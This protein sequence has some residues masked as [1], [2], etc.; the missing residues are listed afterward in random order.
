MPALTTAEKRDDIRAL[1]LIDTR[2]HELA[3]KSDRWFDRKGYTLLSER[4]LDGTRLVAVALEAD[5]VCPIDA[6]ATMQIKYWVANLNRKDDLLAAFTKNIVAIN[7]HMATAAAQRV[8]GIVPKEAKHMTGFLDR[9]A[10]AG[11]CSR[12]DGAEV[13][14]GEGPTE[15]YR[16]FWFYV[17]N[18]QTVTDFMEA[19]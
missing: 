6:T 11:A 16:N 2:H 10:E 15:D 13:S 8:W 12:T 7:A 18:R 3:E 4:A 1:A 9:V 5:S 17:G 19:G 14:Y